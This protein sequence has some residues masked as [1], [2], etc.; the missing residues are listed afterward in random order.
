MY[1]NRSRCVPDNINYR[2]AGV[3][4]SRDMLTGRIIYYVSLGTR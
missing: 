4:L 3:F 1:T 2:S